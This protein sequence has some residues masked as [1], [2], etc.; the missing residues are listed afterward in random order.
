M[1]NKI[2]INKTHLFIKSLLSKY[3]ALVFYLFKN[4]QFLVSSSDQ[5]S[6]SIS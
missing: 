1:L 5:V 3:V 6:S 2:T 4:R